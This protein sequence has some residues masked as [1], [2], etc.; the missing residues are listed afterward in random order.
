MSRWTA[1]CKCAPSQ[2]TVA[3]CCLS[4]HR[5]HFLHRVLI[6][7]LTYTHAQVRR[8]WPRV[9]VN[10]SITRVRSLS[11]PRERFYHDWH[12]SRSD[13]AGYDRAP[14]YQASPTP[15]SSVYSKGPTPTIG[16]PPHPPEETKNGIGV[17]VSARRHFI[18]G[19]HP[20]VV[21]HLQ[22]LNKPLPKN[23]EKCDGSQMAACR[24]SH[25]FTMQR[26]IAFIILT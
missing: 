3:H 6:R 10:C 25:L 1:A 9:D 7:F 4:T 20:K 24:G 16:D 21:I 8:A 5:V 12:N 2:L 18:G 17:G 13:W 15:S 11:S 14:P 22:R 23:E 19:P 26:I